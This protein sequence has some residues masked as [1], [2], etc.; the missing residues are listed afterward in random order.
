MYKALVM[1]YGNYISCPLTNIEGNKLAKNILR[2]INTDPAASRVIAHHCTVNQ[3]YLDSE[4]AKFLAFVQCPSEERCVWLVGEEKVGGKFYTENVLLCLFWLSGTCQWALG[5]ILKKAQD[6][7]LYLWWGTGRHSNAI[8][9]WLY[10]ISDP[11]FSF[12]I[13]SFPD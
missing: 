6:R 5:I 4:C 13:W 10:L 1:I 9:K 7:R 8:E 2:V 12:W 3:I 11:C